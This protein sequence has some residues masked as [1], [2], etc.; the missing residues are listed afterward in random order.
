MT[1]RLT[2]CEGLTRARSRCTRRA[3]FNINVCRVGYHSLMWEPPR[4]PD[5]TIIDGGADSDPVL[6]PAGVS[7]EDQMRYEGLA[8]FFLYGYLAWDKQEDDL[9][10]VMSKYPQEPTEFWIAM[11]K[12]VH[13]LIE[14]TQYGR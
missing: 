14:E 6:L 4:R 9:T 7:P 3:A 1:T 5:L 2:Q 10:W 12:Q 8:R 13:E 11:A